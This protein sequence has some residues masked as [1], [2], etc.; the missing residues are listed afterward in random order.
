ML[1]NLSLIGSAVYEFQDLSTKISGLMTELLNTKERKQT[2]I[3]IMH[4]IE[5]RST[6]TSTVQRKVR[7]HRTSLKSSFVLTVCCCF[8]N[9]RCSSENDC[10]TNFCCPILLHRCL[11][12][13][14]EN[15]AC[16]F[17]VSTSVRAMLEG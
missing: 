3:E 2:K 14:L 17:N 6:M 13:I 16:N 8:I 10:A 5:T 4:A 11:P 12:K 1:K 7:K 9:Q 15:G